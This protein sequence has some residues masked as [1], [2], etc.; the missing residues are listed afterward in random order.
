M[1]S[2]YKL[3]AVLA[4]VLCGGIISYHLIQSGNQSPTGITAPARSPQASAPVRPA[5]SEPKPQQQ[6]G[7]GDLMSRIRSHIDTIERGA[8]SDPAAADSH[9]AASEPQLTSEP[10]GPVPTLTFTHEP[11]TPAPAAEAA[12]IVPSPVEAPTPIT[13]LE[14]PP[15]L[16]DGG[17]QTNNN[18][19]PYTIQ[20]GDTFSTIAVK[21]YG[22]EQH[23]IDIAMANPFVDPKR[24]QIGQAIRLPGF[25]ELLHVETDAAAVAGPGQKTHTVRPG[26]SLYSI[27]ERYYN[28]PNKWRLLFDTNRDQIG[29]DPHQLQAGEQ[30]KIPPMTKAI[31]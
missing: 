18:Q 12:G 27:A 30:L 6:T 7:I 2:S 31:P 23:W 24:L 5:A 28:D 3:A 29:H 25:E 4:V 21:I 10:Q 14:A 17:R 11:T 20:P 16:P 19:E 9:G 13:R 1:S 22:S 15:T 26:E 8:A